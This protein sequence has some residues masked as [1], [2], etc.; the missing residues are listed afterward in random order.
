M[1]RGSVEIRVGI[2]VLA[3]VLILALGLMWLTNFSFEETH[4]TVQ[5]LFPNI[6][7]LET[8]DQV[9]VYGIKRGKVQALQ[10]SQNQ[11]LATIELS[12]DVELKTD[13]QFSVKN[14]GL[15][16][17]RYIDVLPGNADQ[18]LDISRPVQGRYDEGL[19]ELTSVIG[20]MVEEMSELAA[21]LRA[22]VASDTTLSGLVKTM[23]NARDISTEL[24]ATVEEN[25]TSLKTS[26]EDFSQAAKSLREIA[27][28]NQD[29][30]ERVVD[31]M[32]TTSAALT[33]FVAQLD[34][35]ST[36]VNG[37]LQQVERGEGTLGLLVGDD[38]L[39][40]QLKTAAQNLESLI[41]D[42][43]ANPQKYVRVQVKLF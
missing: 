12:N 18:P 29:Q 34:T 9:S 8:G 35:M 7:M 36:Q 2:T 28:T 25:R 37:L 38:E 40:N 41:A 19:T 33:T 14:L 42:I 13:A 16:G 23:Q 32:D 17:E 20:P 5:V 39:Y 11:V 26:L 3:A 21:A 31:R 22:S 4:Y 43:R 6:G 15:M 24:K 1:K 27:S 10:L 30:I